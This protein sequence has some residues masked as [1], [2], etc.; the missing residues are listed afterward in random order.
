MAWNETTVMN[1]LA[2]LLLACELAACVTLFVML[3]RLAWAWAIGKR[4][5]T[6]RRVRGFQVTPRKQRDE[7]PD[8]GAG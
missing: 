7:P 8:G 1:A 5:E 2:V 6:L 4:R 3:V